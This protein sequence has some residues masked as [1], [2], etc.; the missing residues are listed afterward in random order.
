MSR[1]RKQDIRPPG[2]EAVEH[3]RLLSAIEALRPFA[4]YGRKL[5]LGDRRG[6]A[7]K[8]IHDLGDV[9]LTLGDFDV[10]RE[11]VER[12]DNG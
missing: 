12:A 2:Q 1:P 8:T 11:L 5:R 3:E 10:A 4:E 7:R 9:E 6:A